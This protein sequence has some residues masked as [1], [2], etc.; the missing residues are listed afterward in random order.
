MNA[1]RAV[2]E[3]S[4]TRG[5]QRLVM[6][7]LADHASDDSLIGWPSVETL[8]KKANLATGRTV[9]KILRDLEASG[10]IRRVGV[11]RRSVV[12]YQIVLPT[13]VPQGT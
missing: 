8:R 1:L 12:K 9:H 5:G 4:R 11:G 10:E 6:L 3:R 2:F 13:P 7:G